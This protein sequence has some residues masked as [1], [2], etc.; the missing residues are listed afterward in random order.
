MQTCKC[1]LIA[2]FHRPIHSHWSLP[3]NMDLDLKVYL[4]AMCTAVLIGRDL[5]PPP[6]PTLILA[7][8]GGR[9]WSAKIDDITF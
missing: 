4:C 1:R 8:I 2:T 3:L 9:Y 6:P 7:H 5:A